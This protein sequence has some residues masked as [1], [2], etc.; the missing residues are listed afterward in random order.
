VNLKVKYHDFQIVTRAKSLEREVR[1]RS[2]FLE[3]GAALLRGLLPPAKAIRLLGLGLSSLTDLSEPRPE[4]L[5]LE[6]PL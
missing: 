3:I 5:V 6:L 2:E 4:P 1:D